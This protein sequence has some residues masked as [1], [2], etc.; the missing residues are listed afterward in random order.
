MGAVMSST[1]L[2][3]SS[4]RI[5]CGSLTFAFALLVSA[6][7]AVAGC[8][9]GDMLNTHLLSSAACRANA[10]GSSATAVGEFA[11]APAFGATAIGHV[12]FAPGNHATAL[13]AF[14]GPFANVTVEGA[15][16]VGSGT[17]FGGA[18]HYS[19]AVGGGEGVGFNS[20]RA[21]HA[22]GSYSI[23]LGGGDAATFPGAQANGLRSI[24]VG[25]N[26]VGA[27]FG[28]S[29]GF[30]TNTAFASTAIGTDAQ[31]TADSST[32]LGRFAKASANAALAMG[33]GAVA[34]KA[35]SVALGS[36]SLA[37]VADTVSVGT[38]NARRRIVNVAPGA[39]NSDAATLGQ[40]KNIVNEA[41]SNATIAKA[42]GDTVSSDLQRELRQMRSM[43][44][45]LQQEIA[46]LKGQKAAALGE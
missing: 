7:T 3:L 15:T 5:T 11:K 34:S 32:A 45:S 38:N 16:M 44:A 13:G 27:D 25:Q 41:L 40:V 20:T 37:N 14:A 26:S 36:G 2:T 30:N 46:E 24:A 17:G 28:T 39:S 1:R 10:S 18:G 22:K 21:A 12:A 31:A 33:E 43:I 23:A 6:A 8:N 29:V 19:T 42:V 4:H 35:R 9:S